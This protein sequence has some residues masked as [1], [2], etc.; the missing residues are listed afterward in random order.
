MLHHSG[1]MMLEEGGYW[2]P[3]PGLATSDSGMSMDV[4][5]GGGGV[6]MCP[7]RGD[8]WRMGPAEMPGNMHI[9][10][11]RPLLTLVPEI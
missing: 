6:S 10:A 1:L 11:V 2:G 4:V 8:R 5:P 3:L 9:C 7:G